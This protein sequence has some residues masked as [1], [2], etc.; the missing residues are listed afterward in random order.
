MVQILFNGVAM[1]AIYALVALSFVLVYNAV[2]VVNFALYR[3]IQS[4]TLGSG[5]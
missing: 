2:G 3:L 5:F 1:G 4:W